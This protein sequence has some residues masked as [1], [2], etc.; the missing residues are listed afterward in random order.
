MSNTTQEFVPQVLK[1]VVNLSC[2]YYSI[3]LLDE[4]TISMLN[5]KL[6]ELVTVSHD[7]VW[8]EEIKIEMSNEEG[9]SYTG[10][11]T[12]FLFNSTNTNFV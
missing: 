5:T 6:R 7:G 12:T 8:R 10:T 9:E 11:V 1:Q 3:L 2:F 4:T